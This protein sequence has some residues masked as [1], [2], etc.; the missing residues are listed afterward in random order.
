MRKIAFALILIPA[1]CFAG[2]LQQRQMNMLGLYSAA[3]GASET[4]AYTERFDGST[5]CLAGYT[6]NCDNAWKAAEAGTPDFDNTTS[7][8]P[9][10]GTYSLS[11][12]PA[13]QVSFFFTED[14][15]LWTTFK[16]QPD[17]DTEANEIIFRLYDDWALVGYVTWL[18][19]GQFRA[20]NTGGTDQS[21]S[22]SYAGAAP[23]YIR[24]HYLAGSGSDAVFEFWTSTDGT[25]W[26][27]ATT[28]NDGTSTT[29]ADEIHFDNEADTETFVFDILKIKV[30]GTIT[31]AT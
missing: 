17:G 1:L 24:V 20:S 26:S 13:S 9:L 18:L 7:P 5:L 25:S 30:D 10:E 2:S 4:Y 28:S 16:F 14:T 23:I 21:D 19:G 12:P 8:A 6:S 27:S 3:G 11:L 31:D 22:S 15:E 29:A